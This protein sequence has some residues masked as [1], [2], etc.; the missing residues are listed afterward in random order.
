MTAIVELDRPRHPLGH[1]DLAM[2][3]ELRQQMAT[4]SRPDRATSDVGRAHRR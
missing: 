4:D 3:D 2:F 1:L